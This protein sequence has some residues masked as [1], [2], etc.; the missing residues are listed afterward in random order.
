[1]PE[2]L[3]IAMIVFALLGV[4]LLVA[5]LIALRKHR[6]IPTGIALLLA[7]SFL[8]VAALAATLGVAM[9]G[10][11]ALTREVVAAT[12]VTRPTGPERFS[13]TLTFPDGRREHYEITG[14]ALYIDAHIVKW[15]PRA[16]LLGLHTAYQLDRVAGR[17]DRLEDEQTKPRRIFSLSRPTPVDMFQ[18]ARSLA[19]LRRFGR[20]V[21]AEYGSATFIATREPTQLELRVSTSGLLFRPAQTIQG[22]FTVSPPSR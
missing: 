6:W 8:A 4:A 17:Y 16:N 22:A 1:M 13:A 19:F 11:R 12:V 18:V 21:D 9:Q 2:P 3:V 15:H 20:V 14:N 10:Y 7:A 5:A